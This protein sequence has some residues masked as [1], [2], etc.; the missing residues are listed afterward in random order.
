MRGMTKG[1]GMPVQPEREEEGN[2]EA[3]GGES[4]EKPGRA[5][6]LP[7]RCTQL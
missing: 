1:K 6:P 7:K 5:Q 3:R 4:M 2:E